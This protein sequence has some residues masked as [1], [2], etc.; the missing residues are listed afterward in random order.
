MSANGTGWGGGLPH[1]HNVTVTPMFPR[2]LR[3]TGDPAGELVLHDF[4]RVAR[5]ALN[6]AP[7]VFYRLERFRF[8]ALRKGGFDGEK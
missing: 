5:L 1:R 6:H 4:N 7:I 3:A 8:A 2:H